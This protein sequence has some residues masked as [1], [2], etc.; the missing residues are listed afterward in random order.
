[1]LR[2]LFLCAPP[3]AFPYAAF[4]HRRSLVSL[5]FLPKA[6]PGWLDTDYCL[7]LRPPP[8]LLPLWV[9]TFFRS[10]SASVPFSSQ[11]PARSP[12]PSNLFLPFFFLFYLS[13]KDIGFWNDTLPK[14][15]YFLFPLATFL[16]PPPSLP[17]CSTVFPPP[18]QCFPIWLSLIC[19]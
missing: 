18:C 12:P 6:D 11:Q 19:F 8:P 16:L 5:P 10:S 3:L 2:F 17:L 15:A 4:P 1:M 14:I 9:H 7:N 13:T